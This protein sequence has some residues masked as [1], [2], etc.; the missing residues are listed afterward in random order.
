MAKIVHVTTPLKLLSLNKYAY[1]VAMLNLV[2]EAD[3]KEFNCDYK[4]VS[5]LSR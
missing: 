2:M 4:Q 5:I 1:S 3:E